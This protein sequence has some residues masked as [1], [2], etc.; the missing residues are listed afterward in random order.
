MTLVTFKDLK[1]SDSM[2]KTIK[3]GVGMLVGFAADIAISTLLKQYVPVGKGIMRLLAK[4]GIIAIG[5]KV[6]E[7]VETYFYKV[8]DDTKKSWDE[9]K[10]EA[11]KQVAE[12]V[13]QETKNEGG[14]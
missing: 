13:Q 12:M 3:L 11:E 10:K 8:C 7:D 9:A 5:F 2:G 4:L 14:H 1:D 6:G